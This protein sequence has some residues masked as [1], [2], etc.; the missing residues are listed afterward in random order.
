VLVQLDV[1]AANDLDSAARAEIIELCESAYREDFSRLF[2]E[3]PDSVHVL[4][5]DDRGRLV[6]HAEWVTR[7]LQPAEHPVLRTAYVEAV[8]TEPPHQH[9]GLASTVLRHVNAILRSDPVWELGA[10]CPSV[11]ALYARHGWEPWLGPL[12]IRRGESVERTVAGEQVMI[13]RLPRTPMTLT[14]TSLL[15]AE[16]RRGELW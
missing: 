6:S 1:V 16:W 3:L 14:T 10:L 2:Q 4:A 7:W 13:L 9:K 12:G 11:P 15:T 5:R 8:A